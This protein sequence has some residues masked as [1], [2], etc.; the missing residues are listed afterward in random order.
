MDTKIFHLGCSDPNGIRCVSDFQIEPEKLMILPEPYNGC[1]VVFL[2][3][4]EKLFFYG[5]VFICVKR[6]KVN[7]HGYCLDS[8]CGYYSVLCP[9]SSSCLCI[10]EASEEF[11]PSKL[12]C[13]IDP[14][15]IQCSDDFSIASI[16]DLRSHVGYSYE[17]C[18]G[19]EVNIG[20]RETIAERFIASSS[21]LAPTAILLCGFKQDYFQRRQQQPTSQESGVAVITGQDAL[22]FPPSSSDSKAL[23][24]KKEQSQ[25]QTKQRR[26]R[27]KKKQ[28]LQEN[29]TVSSS[30]SS[31]ILTAYVDLHSTH[32]Y[33]EL[34]TSFL[35]FRWNS[36]SIR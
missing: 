1:C 15:G 19:I 20:N 5:R 14:D 10:E 16:G 13:S 9:F 2:Y 34:S 30:S 31:S 18:A 22:F 27:Q 36:S 6:G 26:H 7:I 21:I 32:E 4:H 11:Y 25:Q 12:D 28:S 29:E 17:D 33:A 35:E 8:S 3:P 24:R 23:K